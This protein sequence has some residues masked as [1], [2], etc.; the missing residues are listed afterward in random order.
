[1]NSTLLQLQLSHCWPGSR[2][3][4]RIGL[5][6]HLPPMPTGNIPC[7][8]RLSFPFNEP[9][10]L[11]GGGILTVDACDRSPQHL[12]RQKSTELSKRF[13]T[14]AHMLRLIPTEELS[15]LKLEIVIQV[16]A[17]PA[18]HTHPWLGLNVLFKDLHSTQG[19]K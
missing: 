12:R 15:S 5:L 16:A 6:L 4:H 2:G 11:G 10:T 8:G 7:S 13:Q 3:M 17:G 18:S 19:L 14:V 1:M 9:I